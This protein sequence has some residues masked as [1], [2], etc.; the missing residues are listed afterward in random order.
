MSSRA[1]EC[2]T[3]TPAGPPCSIAT[4][5]YFHRCPRV[6]GDEEED[7]VDDLEN[8]FNFVGGDQQDSK[9]MA[10]VML[11]GHG[12]YGRRVDIKT[13]H[14]AHAVPQV[15]LLT[16]GEMVDDI[17]PDQHALV[18]SFIGGGGKRIHPLPFP[19]PN[20]PGTEISAPRL[21]SST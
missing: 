5:L 16:N 4:L 12:S 3:F 9:Y 15:P 7:D 1:P 13:P 6:A 18:P 11:Q 2:R 20:I 10:E 19:D 17:P 8:E 21:G 14:V